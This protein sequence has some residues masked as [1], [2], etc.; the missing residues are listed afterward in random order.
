MQERIEVVAGVILL[1]KRLIIAQRKKG[2][3]LEGHWEFPGG[4]IEPG[5]EP[6]EALV[7]EIKEELGIEVKPVRELFTLPHRYPDK[8]VNLHFVLAEAKDKPRAL[9]CQD[10][11]V[12]TPEEI[13]KY[14]LAPA[15]RRAWERIERLIRAFSKGP[16]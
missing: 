3:H 5:E 9:E 12:V 10:V 1:G 16:E 13:P 11:A 14:R 7:R 2:D 15:D 4:K 6:E 8:C